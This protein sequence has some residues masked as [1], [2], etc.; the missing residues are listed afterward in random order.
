MA[1]RP[2]GDG[3]MSELA[4]ETVG[5]SK[6][7][8]GVRAV[9]DLS[10]TVEDGSIV[11][12]IGPNGA[13]KTTVFNLVTNLFPPDAGEVRLY[14]ASLRRRGP[15]AI[16]DLGLL[17][18]FQTA[19]VFPGM[20]ALE[21]VL[22]GAHRH[23]R[24]PAAAQVLWLPPA[25]REEA[26]LR[27]QAEAMLDLVGLTR[28]SDAPASSLPMGGQKLVEVCR[29][30]MARPRVL[31]LDE[32]AAGLNDAETAELATLL[33]AV[34]D[35]GVTVVVVEHNMS[36]VMDIA[37]RVIVLDLGRLL[38]EGTPAEIQRD[39]RVIEAYLGADA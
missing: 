17:R 31:L 34:R 14:G 8:G 12:L 25:L 1:V 37:D 26:V 33:R 27:H 36:L 39:P 5:L 11:A 3:T 23:T 6:S 10:F 9:D 21:N 2:L 15:S 22:A 16:A 29:A 20:T 24:V 30:L 38:A 7:F 28:F 35:S 13:G 18:T 32:P 19:R 4:L